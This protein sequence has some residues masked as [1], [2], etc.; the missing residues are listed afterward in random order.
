MKITE[1]NGGVKIVLKS[2]INQEVI[3]YRLIELRTFE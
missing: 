2:L 3:F 1:Y